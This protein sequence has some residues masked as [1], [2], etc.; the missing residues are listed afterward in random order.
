MLALTSSVYIENGMIKTLN[1]KHNN[2]KTINLHGATVIP[3][4]ID[5]HFHLKN[6]GK[7]IEIL[8]LKN[9]HSLE[10]GAY[11]ELMTQ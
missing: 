2:V 10:D 4:F 1:I 3:G 9:I 8:D 6:F 7:R 5:A 11:I